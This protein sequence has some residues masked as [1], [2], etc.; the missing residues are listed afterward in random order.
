MEIREYRKVIAYIKYKIE[1]GELRPGDRLP[2]EREMA[3]ALSVGRYSIREAIRVMEAMGLIESRQGS[4]NYLNVD[5][6]KGFTESMEMMLLIHQVDFS[7]VSQLRRAIEIFAYGCA[8]ESASD[9]DI[10]DLEDI[11]SNMQLASGKKKVKYDKMFH[12]RII[13]ITGNSLII[14]IMGALSTVCE[15]LISQ[16]IFQSP[17]DIEGR[18]MDTHRDMLIGLKAKDAA[19]GE[20]AVRSHYDLT[21][22]RIAGKSSSEN[23]FGK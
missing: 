7:Q 21:D 23:T 15:S 17:P 13:G 19:F 9:A 2:A 10:K 11:F 4:G 20:K 14:N 22:M 5:I 12:D 18:I 16:V 8:A 6:E 1:I 3:E